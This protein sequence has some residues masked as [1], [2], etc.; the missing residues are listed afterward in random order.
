[1]GWR[2]RTWDGGAGHGMLQ[3]Q[4]TTAQ[5]R[6]CT[7]ILSTPGD[8][9]C[10]Q[11]AGKSRLPRKKLSL[12]NPI[13]TFCSSS[14]IWEADPGHL[15]TS[16]C[17]MCRGGEQSP[18][19]WETSPLPCVQARLGMQLCHITP[20][21]EKCLDGT[22]EQW[23]GGTGWDQSSLTQDSHSQDFVLCLGEVAMRHSS[24]RE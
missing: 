6:L 7:G 17:Q 15:A 3:H 22:W 8:G 23:E 19:G 1:M 21:L 24:Y 4:S 14:P 16:A 18:C 2:C 9:E 13:Q 20:A 12:S 11:R 10:V 5:P